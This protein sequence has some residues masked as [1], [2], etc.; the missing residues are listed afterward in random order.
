MM[1]DRFK[2]KI[3]LIITIDEYVHATTIGRETTAR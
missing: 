3:K 1:E 2:E